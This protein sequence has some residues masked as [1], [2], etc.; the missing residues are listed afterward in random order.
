MLFGAAIFTLCLDVPACVEEDI[1][2]D[3]YKDS[4][5]PSGSGLRQWLVGS[6]GYGKDGMGKDRVALD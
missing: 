1:G 2:V 5:E 3:M 6:T 4:C